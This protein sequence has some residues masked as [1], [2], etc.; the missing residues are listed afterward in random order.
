M[1]NITFQNVSV[2]Y[3]NKKNN[4]IT[5]L[6]NVSFSFDDHLFHV[7]VGPSGGG[8]TTVIKCLTGEIIY[9]GKITFDDTDLE[10]ISIKDRKISYMTQDYIVYPSINVYDN[11]AF[12][13]R[14]AKM[15]HDEADQ[16]I[17]DIAHKLDIDLL[18]TRKSKYLS[19]GQVSRVALAKALVKD[20]ELFLFDEPTKNLD[21]I[22]RE[23]VVGLIKDNVKSRNKTVIYV[24]HDIKEAI[25]IADVIHVINNG[26]YIG[27]F[28]PKQFLESDDEVVKSLRVD[29]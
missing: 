17:K 19:I 6:D 15:D 23:K 4:I 29:L 12:P 11:V 16:K 2:L 20:S 9:E 18:L 24:T 1:S 13:L 21:A 7:I 5:A 10:S 26:K 3:E 22:N 27:P 28:T 8:K 14:V 25:N